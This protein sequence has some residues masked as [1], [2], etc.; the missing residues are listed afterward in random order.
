MS[1]LHCGFS[2]R[3]T[4]KMSLT[5]RISC[6]NITSSWPL[7]VSL[8]GHIDECGF[9]QSVD[10][11]RGVQ[12]ENIWET[13][14]RDSWRTPESHETFILALFLCHLSE[15]TLRWFYFSSFAFSKT[16]FFIP[17]LLRVSIFDVFVGGLINT[18]LTSYSLHNEE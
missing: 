4:S 11:C 6:A 9:W 12:N 2:S 5:T 8:Y 13:V 7:Q 17:S 14:W 18:I 16:A 3:S 1:I 15:R 10:V